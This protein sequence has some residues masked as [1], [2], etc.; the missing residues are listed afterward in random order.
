[1]MSISKIFGVCSIVFGVIIN[2]LIFLSTY[3]DYFSH[4]GF[5][6]RIGFLVCYSIL[7]LAGIFLLLKN[8]LSLSLYLVFSLTI[9]IDRLIVYIIFYEHLPLNEY[10]APFLTV[11]FVLFYLLYFYLK[12]TY[13]KLT[14]DD[15]D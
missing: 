4:P 5:V 10:L 2:I 12:K 7:V 9:I 11:L 15:F 14:I 6:S 1:M 8:K 3:I 13:P